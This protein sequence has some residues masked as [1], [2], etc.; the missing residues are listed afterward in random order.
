[1]KKHGD[2]LGFAFFSF[3][4]VVA[5]LA[6][7]EKPTLLAWLAV[8]HNLILA[9][10]YIVRNKEARSN[11][12]GLW[13]GLI[14]SMLPMTMYTNNLPTGLQVS[15]LV[16]YGLILW[17]LLVLG[18]S[19]GI[20]PA[21]RG[22]VTIAPYNLVRHP[23]YLG[24]LIFRASIVGGSFTVWNIVLLAVLVSIQI[25]RIY[26]EEKIIT[27]YENYQTVTRWRLIPGIW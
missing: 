18:K 10:L 5:T 8:S 13:L 12:K 2:K 1:M 15:G 9:V 4:A 26:M 20:A 7:V 3:G 27:G 25:I 16:G 23:M 14:A 21:D 19:F 24:E 6:A 11:R 17:S 22:L